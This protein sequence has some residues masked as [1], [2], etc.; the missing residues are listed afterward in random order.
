MLSFLQAG[1]CVVEEEFKIFSFGNANRSAKCLLE[2]L[3]GYVLHTYLPVITLVFD[4]RETVNVVRICN[5]KDH[6]TR[7]IAFQH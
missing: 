1:R 2:D 5:K 7:A 4:G 3:Q 6:Q